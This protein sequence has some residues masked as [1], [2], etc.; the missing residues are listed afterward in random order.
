MPLTAKGQEILE[1]FRKEYGAEGESKFYAA[2]NAG[3]ITGVDDGYRMRAYTV[4]KIG[5]KRE[6]TPEGFLICYDVPLARIGEQIYGPDETPV[7]PRP[8]VPYVTI[9][10]EPNE[11]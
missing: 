4:E 3:T 7:K 10:R 5:P 6:R 1:H 11:V 8:G 2:R 9:K